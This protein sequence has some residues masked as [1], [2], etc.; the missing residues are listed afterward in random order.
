VAFTS[1]DQLASAHS[2]RTIRLWG[3]KAGRVDATFWG[4]SGSVLC[5]AANREGSRLVSA[6]A[7]STIRVWDAR[8]GE[9]LLVCRGHR[10]PVFTAAFLPDG[11]RVISGGADK[12][13]KIWHTQ[14]N[15]EA[16]VSRD[17]G[18]CTDLA[19]NVDGSKL[20]VVS[21]QGLFIRN[22]TGPYENLQ[23]GSTRFAR[24]AFSP[25]G[26]RVAIGNRDG[27]AVRNIKSGN[28]VHLNGGSYGVAF[29]PDG[30]QIASSGV[31]IWDLSSGEQLRRL[32]DDRGVYAVAFSPDGR[33]LAAGGGH[34]SSRSGHINLWDLKTG[35]L[36]HTMVTEPFCVWGLSFSKDGNRLASGAGYYQRDKPATAPGETRGRVQVWDTRTGEALCDWP[37]LACVFCVA[38]SPDGSR[39]ASGGGFWGGQLVGPSD[40]TLWDT[41]YRREVLRLHGHQSTIYGLAFSPD[42]QTLASASA[43]GTVRIWRTLVP[44]VGK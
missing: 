2:D 18:F 15:P 20:A 32:K 44:P 27:V 22:G 35:H 24:L 8:T 38:I 36:V 34:F 25:D 11:Q 39:V 30:S 12:A 33:W 7:D 1:A 37:G 3:L 19:F 17:L 31:L 43:D 5:V 42:G 16:E 23:V 10:G 6:S 14:W 9:Q 26:S 4:H 40:V 41:I 29:S 21:S 28:A 13:A